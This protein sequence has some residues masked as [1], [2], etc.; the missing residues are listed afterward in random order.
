M[1]HVLIQLIVLPAHPAFIRQ[2]NEP[3]LL[4]YSSWTSIIVYM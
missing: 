2:E 3:Y 4:R 1:A